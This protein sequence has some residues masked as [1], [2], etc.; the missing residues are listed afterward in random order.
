MEFP[1]YQTTAAL[2]ARTGLVSLDVACRISS[3]LWFYMSSVVLYLLLQPLLTQGCMYNHCP[4]ICMDPVQH[5]LEPYVSTRPCCNHV[6]TGVHVCDCEGFEIGGQA[7]LVCGGDPIR[8]ARRV[9]KSY[10][11]GC[12][13]RSLGGHHTYPPV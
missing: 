8:L 9:D 2:L 3:L 13:G 7:R 4:G 1:L 6:C 11:H 10:D 5:F 12:S